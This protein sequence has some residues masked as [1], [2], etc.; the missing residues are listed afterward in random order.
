[1]DYVRRFIA[2]NAKASG[3]ANQPAF[4]GLHEDVSAAQ[5][6]NLR[7]TDAVTKALQTHQGITKNSEVCLIYTIALI[8]L[9]TV[10]SVVRGR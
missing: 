2:V 9:T 6:A 7:T 5:C 1:M 4:S 8:N 3:F 10:R